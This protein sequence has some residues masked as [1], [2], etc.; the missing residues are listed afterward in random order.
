MIRIPRRAAHAAL[1]ALFLCVPAAA[2]QVKLVERP[3]QPCVTVPDTARGILTQG[4]LREFAAL[5]DTL[6]AL[7]KK[8]GEAD[9][10]GLLF[11]IVDSSAV[12]GRV[13][14]LQ[15]NLPQAAVDA[16]TRRMGEYLRGITPGRPFQMLVRVDGEYPALAPG[17][18]HCLPAVRDDS[19]SDLLVQQTIRTHP[20]RAMRRERR[21]AV[22]R[23]VVD[24]E[25]N[26]AYVD[27]ER[28]TGDTHLDKW[29]EPAASVLRFHPATLDGV[30]F[31][32]R[33]RYTLHLNPDDI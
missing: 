30:P 2:Q 16:G 9:P 24:R 23:L 27:V 21:R 1:L 4:Q 10:R 18:R 12:R 3:G 7:G 20:D 25:G 31:D 33:I 5:R 11:V 14:F 28:P 19:R 15:S 29:I 8:H 6:S 22:L 32:V 26:V 13:L 17:K